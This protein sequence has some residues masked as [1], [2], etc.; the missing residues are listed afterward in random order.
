[1]NILMSSD[2]TTY[3][4]LELVIYTMLTHNKNVDFY[5]FTMDMEMDDKEHCQ[6]FVYRGLSDEQKGKL[7]KIVKYLDK[8]SRITFIDG[9]PYWKEY[10]EGGPN[11]FSL[12][13]PY[14]TLRLIADIALPH[15]HHCLYLDCDVAITGDISGVYNDYIHRDCNY[16]AWIAEDAFGGKGEMVSGVMIMNLD[17]LRQSGFFDLARKNYLT[18]K[19]TFP[20]QTAMS[21]AEFPAQLPK[22]FGYCD[23]LEDCY[24]LPLVIH[25]TNCLS[26]KI[27]ENKYIIRTIFFRKYPFLKYADDGIHRIDTFNF[28]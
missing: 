5:I 8:N 11:Q 15:V 10:L 2:S 26:P 7:R 24:T 25:F 22:N 28:K 16:A 27:Y 1:M 17:K 3:P 20:D 12:F 13:T 4:G 6:M 9:Y 19:Y 14:A 21:D 18:N 23:K